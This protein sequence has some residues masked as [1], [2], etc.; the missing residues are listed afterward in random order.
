VARPPSRMRWP[1]SKP[2]TAVAD[3]I[4]QRHGTVCEFAPGINFNHQR[5]RSARNHRS[6]YTTMLTISAHHRLVDGRPDR[7]LSDSRR[8]ATRLVSFWND[9]N[10]ALSSLP[11]P[12]LGLGRS[13]RARAGAVWAMLPA[14]TMLWYETPCFRHKVLAEYRKGSGIELMLSLPMESN[15]NAL[16]GSLIITVN[17]AAACAATLPDSA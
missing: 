14:V 11:S 8:R 17:R 3:V 16:L 9:R 10:P 6:T 4:R 15:W 1:E 13:H 12:S 7:P 5:R 2:P